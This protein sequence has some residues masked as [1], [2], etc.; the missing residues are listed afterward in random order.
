M[1]DVPLRNGAKN[2]KRTWLGWNAVARMR[3]PQPPSRSG[4]PN[5]NSDRTSTK[6]NCGMRAVSLSVNL[7]GSMSADPHAVSSAG[8]QRQ[9]L[10][11]G[12]RIPANS[13]RHSVSTVANERRLEQ[14]QAL[15]LKSV[16][17]QAIAFVQNGELTVKTAYTQASLTARRHPNP[18]PLS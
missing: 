13:T 9:I 2:L 14:Q 11:S 18:S 5:S 12:A 8:G 1:S 3:E 7:P 16:P 15:L 10:D 4:A 17:L 6:Q